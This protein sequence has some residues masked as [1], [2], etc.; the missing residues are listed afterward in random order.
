MPRETACLKR[1][2]GRR[3]GGGGSAGKGEGGRGTGTLVEKDFVTIDRET[4][5]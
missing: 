4:S 3:G 2:G 1:E 5:L